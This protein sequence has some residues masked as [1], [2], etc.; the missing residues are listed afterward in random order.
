MDDWRRSPPALPL[1][2][3]QDASAR[4]PARIVASL[5]NTCFAFKDT[6]MNLA[7]HSRS[8]IQAAVALVLLS[9]VALA[10]RAEEAVA[11]AD[12]VATNAGILQ[13]VVP[14]SLDARDE[15]R[16]KSLHD[17]LMI[18]PSQE[19][20]WSNVTAVMRT[21]DEAIDAL[22]KTRHDNALTMSAVA[23][24]RSYGEITEA[25]ATGIRNFEPVFAV[26]YESM[27]SE[28]KLNADKVFRNADHNKSKNKKG[29]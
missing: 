25:H 12:P 15:R 28:Q 9:A 26:L 13:P 17:R 23:D 6:Y 11:S 10:A 16:I 19:A 8:G 1:A 29:T 14:A 7:S 22:A 24:L 21:N 3:S 2:Q 18:S 27:T 5:R 4:H 20:L